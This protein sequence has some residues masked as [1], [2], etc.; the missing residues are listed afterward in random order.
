S[1]GSD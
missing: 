1:V